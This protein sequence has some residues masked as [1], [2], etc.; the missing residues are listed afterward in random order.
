MNGNFEQLMQT[1]YRIDISET[2]VK[3]IFKE[4]NEQQIASE[5]AF[6]IIERQNKK[7]LRGARTAT[8]SGSI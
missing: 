8:I 6:L 1:L 3:R 2:S 5:L 7:L 4:T